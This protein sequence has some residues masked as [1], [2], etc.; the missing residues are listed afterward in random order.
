MASRKETQKRE[1]PMDVMPLGLKLVGE[2]ITMNNARWDTPK[3]C[4]DERHV[5]GRSI[6]INRRNPKPMTNFRL[7]SLGKRED[8][9]SSAA[10]RIADRYRAF[11]RM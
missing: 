9:S 1:S 11:G 8:H 3:R 2:R 4:V 10:R 7:C 5:A 6:R